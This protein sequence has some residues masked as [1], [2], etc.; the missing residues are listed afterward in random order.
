MGRTYMLMTWEE[1]SPSMFIDVAFLTNIFIIKISVS[2]ISPCRTHPTPRYIYLNTSATSH[3]L[4]LVIVGATLAE[5]K[6]WALSRH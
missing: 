1:V 3:Q 2:H 5:W 6:W 4:G